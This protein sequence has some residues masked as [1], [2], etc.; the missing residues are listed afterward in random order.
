[1][2][3]K[4]KDYNEFLEI[5]N[6]NG[7]NIYAKSRTYLRPR[8]YS[9]LKRGNKKNRRNY[10]LKLVLL[11]VLALALLFFLIVLLCKGCRDNKNINADIVGVWYY[12]QY[13]EYQFDG[14]GNGCMCL[15]SD[16]HFEFRYKV[17]ENILY[18]DFVLDYVTDCQYTYTVC[19]NKLTLVGD[20]GTAE[21]GKV[22]E[23]TKK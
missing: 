7:N 10:Y 16:T 17:K 21:I 1:M 8:Q 18:F 5:R 11:S 9:S 15:D 3:I 14:K 2:N 6:K 23:L 19:G 13:T 20:I 12:D 22:Y 4:D